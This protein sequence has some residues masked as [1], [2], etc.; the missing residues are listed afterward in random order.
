MGS[1]PFGSQPFGAQPFGSQ[2]V[3]SQPLG[4]QP[5]GSLP[6][7]A[8]PQASPFGSQPFPQPG[9]YPGQGGG[10]SP[11]PPIADTQGADDHGGIVSTYED[12]QRD[13]SF[14]TRKL[15]LPG[16]KKKGFFDGLFKK[17]K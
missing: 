16:E 5:Y 15:P 9:N 12:M 2:S 11:M 10:P 3:G 17:D 7:G 4:N 6:Q 14:K 13:D 1:Q 8:P